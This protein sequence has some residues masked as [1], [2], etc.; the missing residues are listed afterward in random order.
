MI[1]GDYIVYNKPV[2]SIVI[3]EMD[4]YRSGSNGILIII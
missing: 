2:F 4:T 3:Y 1:L